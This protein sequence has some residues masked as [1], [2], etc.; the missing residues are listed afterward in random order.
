[1]RLGAFAMLIGA[2]ILWL[3]FMRG[4][5]ETAVDVLNGMVPELAEMDYYPERNEF[6]AVQSMTEFDDH[7]MQQYSPGIFHGVQSIHVLSVRSSEAVGLDYYPEAVIEIWVYGSGSQPDRAVA[8]LDSLRTAN[9]AFGAPSSWWR[10]GDWL[11]YTRTRAEMFRPHL[12]EV[13]GVVRE[14]L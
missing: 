9:W 2:G 11:V 13:T 12:E 1:M 6:P 5:E 7:W 4:S 3:S 8:V 10:H 14:A